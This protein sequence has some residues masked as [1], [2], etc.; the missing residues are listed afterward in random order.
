M[1]LNILLKDSSRIKK[2]TKKGEKFLKNAKY[3]KPICIKAH[4]TKNMF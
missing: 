3:I 1:R 2:G 4:A